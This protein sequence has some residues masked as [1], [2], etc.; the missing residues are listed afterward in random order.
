M[1]AQLPRDL[2]VGGREFRERVFSGAI[3]KLPRAGAEPARVASRWLTN[4][5]Q[6]SLEEL[7]LRWRAADWPELNV[8]QKAFSQ[9]A[10]VLR[11][12]H[13]FVAQLDPQARIHIGQPRLRVVVP[14]GH[15]V[16][17]AAPAYLP[18]RDTWFANSEAQINWWMP[19]ARVSE[20]MSFGFSP[21]LFDRPVPNNSASFDYAQWMA[22]GGFQRAPDEPREY[23]T[24]TLAL[25]PRRFSCEP[26]ELL[27]FAAAHLHQTMP[28]D[29]LRARISV[30]FRTVWSSD[31]EE[32]RGA[33][34]VDN[35]SRG[36]ATLDYCQYPF[37]G[38]CR[39]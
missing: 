16:A 23:P 7:A 11:A 22:S 32:K 38:I 17:R 21:E 25:S 18:H 4:H 27:C 1:F 12:V 33:P 31:L 37:E 35:R 8:I 36:C 30:D 9:D 13:D 26:D 2:P 39:R 5:C 29:G 34:N 3:Y 15:F 28:V 20:S 24:T 19:L 6:A 10:D 14:D